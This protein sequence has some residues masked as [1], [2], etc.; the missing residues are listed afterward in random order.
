MV[1]AAA[2]GNVGTKQFAPIPGPTYVSAMVPGR[3]YRPE[4]AFAL[5][6]PGNGISN[7]GP[8]KGANSHGEGHLL[9][10]GTCMILQI[11]QSCSTE[12]EKPCPAGF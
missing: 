8:I 3:G 12:E 6:N 10:L 5:T 9:T 4:N 1:C 2:D 7:I 11:P